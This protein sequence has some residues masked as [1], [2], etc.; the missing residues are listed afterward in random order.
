MSVNHGEALERWLERLARQHPLTID[1]GL[2]RVAGVAARLGLL[3]APL[4]PRVIT[5]AGTNGKGS[6]VAMIE[7]CARAHGLSCVS[8][9]SPHLLRYNERVRVDGR[10]IGDEELITAFERIEAARR[11]GDE[12][13][14]SYFEV[15]TLAA[16]LV[17]KQRAPD[18]AVLEVGLGGR[19]DAVNLFDADVAVITTIAQD[20]AEYLGTDLEI[21]GREKAGIMRAGAC[22]VLGSRSL[23]VS[24]AARAAAVGVARL[25]TL[26]ETFDHARDAESGWRW[27]GED[28]S[29]AA[30]SFAP[31][32]DPGL[33]LDNAASAVQ[34]LVLAGVPLEHERLVAGFAEV[35]LPG[36]LQRIQRWWLDVAHNP[37]AARYLA[38]RLRER[39]RHQP[40]QGRRLVLLAMLGDKDADGVIEA[41]MPVVDGWVCA[42]LD[43]ERGR[44]GADLVAR[45]SAQGGDVFEVAEGVVEAIEW[46]EADP[47][48]VGDEVLVCGSFFT[49]SKALEWLQERV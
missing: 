5:V 15:G 23:P 25:A 36:R 24:V 46:I 17:V 21:I 40:R 19:L 34:A 47:Q 6:T 42:G 20:H 39:D 30:L 4:A 16:A 11:Q 31:L 37:H 10:E 38:E 12:I 18:I 45:I 49:V 33:P 8:Y 27:H 14:L 2:E 9:T 13:S 29:G 22:A 44:S 1:L 28:A 7:S 26:G 3:E 43:G 32:P 35:H 48:F 41:L